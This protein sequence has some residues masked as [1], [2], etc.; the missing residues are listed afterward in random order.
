M[1]V[2]AHQGGWDE[3][4]LF[5]IPVVVALV[6]VRLVE[7]RAARRDDRA[8]TDEHRDRDAR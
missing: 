2:I 3:V 4:L 1:I 6:A 7:R 5:A 8:N